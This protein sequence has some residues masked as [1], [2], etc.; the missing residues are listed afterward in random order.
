MTN[1]AFSPCA[2]K[3]EQSDTFSTAKGSKRT[4]RYFSLGHSTFFPR[5]PNFPLEPVIALPIACRVH[6][7]YVDQI[8]CLATWPHHVFVAYGW[9]LALGSSNGTSALAVAP[10]ASGSERTKCRA[11]QVEEGNSRTERKLPP[12]RWNN[13]LTQ[14]GFSFPRL[15]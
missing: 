9:L 14:Q 2:G 4:S 11:A 13:P 15:F 3:S 1:A 10:F 5:H 7:R 8:N 6:L 12:G